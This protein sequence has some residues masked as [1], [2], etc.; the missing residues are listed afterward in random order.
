MLDFNDRVFT[1]TVPENCKPD[2]FFCEHHNCIEP[3][4]DNLKT[5]RECRNSINMCNFK[6]CQRIAVV[7]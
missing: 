7:G 6:R 4:S 3:L 1:I 2:C 5:C